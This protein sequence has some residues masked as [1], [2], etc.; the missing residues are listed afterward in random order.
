MCHICSLHSASKIFFPFRENTFNE[1]LEDLPMLTNGVDALVFPLTTQPPSFD[2]EKFT[3]SNWCESIFE[4]GGKSIC[5]LQE[6][7]ASSPSRNGILHANLL[8]LDKLEMVSM[9]FWGLQFLVAIISFISTLFGP[10]SNCPPF[11]NDA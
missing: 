2:I 5:F 9:S 11:W 8:C 7:N 4:L 10:F 3:R 6:P 1:P